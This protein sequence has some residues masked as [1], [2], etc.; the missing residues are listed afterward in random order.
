[1]R[2]PS[3]QMPTFAGGP[4]VRRPIGHPAMAGAIGA[5]RRNLEAAISEILARRIAERPSAVAVADCLEIN[6]PHLSDSRL[7]K[8]PCRLPL[9]FTGQGRDEDRISPGGAGAGG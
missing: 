9:P 1:M 7:G 8:D 3:P 6:P 4:H 2:T 5:S